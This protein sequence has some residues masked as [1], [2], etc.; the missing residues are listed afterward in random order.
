MELNQK[1]KELRIVL[2]A[3]ATSAFET[4]VARLKEEMST[5]KIQASH[6]V[7]FLVTDFM[8]AHFEKDKDILIAEFFDSDAYHES[9]RKK[10]KGKENYEELMADALERAKR[11]KGKRRR[12]YVRKG[13][14]TPPSET[15]EGGL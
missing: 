5:I 4:M 2:N 12:K 14:Q 13:T 8:E 3:A 1:E 10:A 15:K 7:S 9:E 11:I 6:F